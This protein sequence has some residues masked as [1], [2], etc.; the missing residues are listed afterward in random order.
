MSTG[1][2]PGSG[3]S[4][5]PRTSSDARRCSGSSRRSAVELRPE[6]NRRALQDLVRPA[7]L[8]VLPFE[9]LDPLALGR[10]QAAPGAGINLGLADPLADRL[11]PDPQLAGNIGHRAVAI[12]P[13]GGR[14]GDQPDRSLT[15]L[16]WIPPRNRTGRAAV[17]WHDSILQEMEPPSDPGRF[18]PRSWQ[19]IPPRL[20]FVAPV[21]CAAS[22]DPLMHKGSSSRKRYGHRHSV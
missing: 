15:E 18:R 20:V 2:S 22:I 3:R 9:L 10:R 17:V 1:R 21:T 11:G 12:T 14:L 4:A 19:A 6:E 8:A 13:F 7:E 5:R 16:G